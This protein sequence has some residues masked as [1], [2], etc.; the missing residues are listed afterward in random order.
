MFI[1]TY[2][3]I[4]ALHVEKKNTEN[5]IQIINHHEDENEY[6]DLKECS[7][8]DGEDNTCADQFALYQT[9]TS[10]HHIYLNHPFD[11]KLSTI[12]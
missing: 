2:R 10:N 11:C 5:I 9:D 3:G 6:H 4:Y 8:I 12:S 7:N 1:C